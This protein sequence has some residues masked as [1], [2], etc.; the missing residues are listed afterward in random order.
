MTPNLDSTILALAEVRGLL[1]G[2][3]KIPGYEGLV[4]SKHLEA[5][6]RA[7]GVLGKIEGFCVDV[8]TFA[9]DQDADAMQAAH[10]TSHQLASLNE[11]EEVAADDQTT[12]RV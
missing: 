7:I 1:T 5:L 4:E 10:K 12:R 8:E 11:L 2:F 6:D 3:N 9:M